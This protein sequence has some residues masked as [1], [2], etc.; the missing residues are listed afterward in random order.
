[1]IKGTSG[2]GKST[3]AKHLA[4]RL[5]L[6]MVGLDSLHHGP[7]WTALSTE[8]FRTEVNSVLG[9]MSDGWVVDGNYDSKL[10]DTVLDRADIIVWLDLPLLV[11]FVRV[12]KRSLHRIFHRVDLG[13]GN[14]ETWRSQFASR[15]SIFMEL[16]R[17]H[18]RHRQIWPSRFANDPRV[19]RLRSEREIAGWI[20]SL[21]T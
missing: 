8:E 3:V 5:D 9:G 15:D 16:V 1:M 19:V 17:K 10:G 4:T 20:E 6:P 11:K 18:R 21:T 7:N 2:S 12:L 13:Y 14:R